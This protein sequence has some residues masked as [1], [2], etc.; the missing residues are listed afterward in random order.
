M[1]KDIRKRTTLN[2]FYNCQSDLT[3]EEYK[4]FGDR[5]PSS[6]LKLGLLGRGGFSLVWLGVQKKSKRRVAIKQILS[7]NPHQTHLK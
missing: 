7:K 6:F 2:D 3:E 5:F 1:S 4:N